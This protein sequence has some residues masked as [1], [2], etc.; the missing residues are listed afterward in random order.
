MIVRKFVN[1]LTLMNFSSLNAKTKLTEKTLYTR[2]STRPSSSALTFARRQSDRQTFRRQSHDTDKVSL[3][4]MWS[5]DE[6]K[7]TLHIFVF[8]LLLHPLWTCGLYY[9]PMTIVNDNSR[10][11]NKLEASLTDDARVI[12]YDC[13]MFIVQA[14]S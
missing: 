12:I 4:I 6:N 13:H 8:K 11:I 7:C 10:V 14:I 3:N 9:K 1:A 2:S 5:S